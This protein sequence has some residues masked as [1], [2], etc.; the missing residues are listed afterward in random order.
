MKTLKESLLSGMEDT[1]ARGEKDIET[2][3]HIPTVKDFIKNPY[4]GKQSSVKWMCPFI[5]DTY[6]KKYPEMVSDKWT[7]IE[8]IL[9]TYNSRMTDLHIYLTDSTEFISHKKV[10]GGWTDTFTGSNL[11]TYKKMTIEI[12]ESLA[13]NTKLLDKIMEHAFESFKLSKS[14]N[15]YLTD[16]YSLYSL[17][18]E[19][20][21]VRA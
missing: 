8:F 13:K 9:E 10:L 16:V 21:T 7:G 11:R 17:A 6:K 4:F 19:N 1:L 20:K 3:L 18:K 5:L 2:A 12:I 15:S 14:G